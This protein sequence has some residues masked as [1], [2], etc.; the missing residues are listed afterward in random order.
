[1]QVQ[2]ADA[3]GR[4]VE[5]G[6]VGQTWSRR[7]NGVQVLLSTALSTLCAHCTVLYRHCQSK[8]H[9][10]V[11]SLRYAHGTPMVY[12]LRSLHCTAC[13]GLT[14]L[15]CQ[16]RVHCTIY[17]LRRALCRVHCNNALS[18]NLQ[19]CCGPTRPP[20]SD[21]HVRYRITPRHPLL[22]CVSCLNSLFP[23]SSALFNSTPLPTPL[24]V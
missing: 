17:A 12:T 23:V 19:L 16:P 14:A 6:G 10:A 2:G 7:R 15:Y 11:Y 18:I 8:A 20:G 5:L 21:R 4:G 9:C 1:M 13:L 3:D 24:A 22:A